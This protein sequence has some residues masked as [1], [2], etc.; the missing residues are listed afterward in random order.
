MLRE[1]S[2]LHGLLLLLFCITAPPAV[3]DSTLLS[4]L[5]GTGDTPALS[6]LQVSVMRAGRPVFSTALGFAQVNEARQRPLT[7][8]HKVRVASISK[9][10]VAIGVMQ[11]VEQGLIDLDVDVSAYL[12]WQLRN[13]AFPD[14][15]ITTRQLLSHTSSIRD[16]R[17]YFLRAGEGQLKDFFQPGSAVWDEGEHFDL[18]PGRHPGNYFHYANLNF[19]LLG[20]IIERRSGLRFDRYMQ[21]RVLAPLG[22]T[23][24]FD[25]CRVPERLLAA[26]FRT[27]ATEQQP[28]HPGGRWYA[29]VDAPPVSCFYGAVDLDDPQGFIEGYDLGS[30]ASLYSPQGGLRASADELLQVL[31]ML[32]AA[33]KWQDRQI[34]LPATVEAMLTPVWQLAVDGQNGETAGEAEPGG[35]AVGLMTSYGLSVHVIDLEAWGF[36]D[37]PAVVVGHLG[38]AYGVLSHALFDP[39]TGDGIATIITG[40]ADDPGL[41]PGH[42]PLYRVEEK[43]IQWWLDRFH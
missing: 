29:Q 38:E 17:R 22:M 43:I 35:A 26:G 10:V 37:A 7:P 39:R 31:Q 40:T 3:S 8:E 6:G 1:Y 14:H 12:A 21:Q 13:P 11:L 9:L 34:L 2:L 23:G 25:P 33:G 15:V 5:S 19:G 20:E 4:L 41:R 36:A 24:S 42:S 16:G 18:S 28:W 32:A 27:R 30:N